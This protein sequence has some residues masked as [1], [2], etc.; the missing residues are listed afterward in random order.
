MAKNRPIWVQCLDLKNIFI[1]K[2][3]ILDQ[4]VTIYVEKIIVTLVF[5]KH[6]KFFHHK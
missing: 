2:L 5:K 6:A 3:S 1:K 4:I